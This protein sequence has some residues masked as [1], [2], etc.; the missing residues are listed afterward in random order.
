MG[1]RTVRRI[2]VITGG[3]ALAIAAA[4]LTLHQRYAGPGPLESET[5]IV[6]P[7]GAGLLEIGRKLA[8]GGVVADPWVFALGARITGVARVLKAGEYAFQPGISMAGAAALIASGRTVQ[9]RLTIAEGLTTAEILALLAETEGVVGARPEPPGE[10]TLL[11]QT[12]FYSHGDTPAEIIQRMTR[13]MRETI[14]ELWPNRAPNLPIVTPAEAVVLASIVEKETALADER[15]RI[16]AVFLNRLRRGMKLQADP[17]VVYAVTQGR[18]P[19]ERPLSRADLE[20]RSPYNTY[21]APA[22]PPGPIANPGRDAI[23]AVLRP[24]VTDEL[25]FVA[26]G[27]GGHAFARTLDEHN[28]NV[29]RLRARERA[30]R[31]EN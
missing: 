26:D 27:N 6:V 11:P 20:L 4:A 8:E 28:R 3:L 10:G 19:L 25:Y 2:G 23:A 9:R 29:A 22:L 30:A 1:R 16:A 31:G 24:A 18:A 15:P 13:A 7:K 17:T 21:L 14:A 5:W 12:Y